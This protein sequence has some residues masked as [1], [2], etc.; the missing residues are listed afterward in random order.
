MSNRMRNRSLK[1]T[2]A[3]LRR[4]EKLTRLDYSRFEFEDGSRPSPGVMSELEAA[5]KLK[6][7]FPDGTRIGSVFVLVEP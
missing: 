5:G 1:S 7:T 3:K 4:G 2:I 6:E